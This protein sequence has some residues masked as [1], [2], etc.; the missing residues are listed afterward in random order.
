MLATVDRS[1]PTF[2]ATCSWVRWNS[3]WRRWKAW[4]RRDPWTLRFTDP[5]M[6]RSYQHADQAEGMRRLRITSLVAAVV[7][8]G[9]IAGC[10]AWLSIPFWVLAMGRALAPPRAILPIPETAAAHR[11]EA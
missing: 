4:D 1:R 11:K 5:N 7:W 9:L 2:R 10:L 6:E 8:V 3:S